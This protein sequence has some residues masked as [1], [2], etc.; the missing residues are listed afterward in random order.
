MPQGIRYDKI[1]DLSKEA[2]I[3]PDEPRENLKLDLE[4]GFGGTLVVRKGPSAPPSQEMDLT[5]NVEWPYRSIWRGECP[6]T[7][8]YD[9]LI[10]RG[11]QS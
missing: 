6:T 11:G 8:L 9:F 7:Q 4:L 1:T 10:E 3:L 5:L 2:T